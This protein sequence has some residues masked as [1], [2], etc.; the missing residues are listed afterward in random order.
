MINE[1]RNVPERRQRRGRASE[2][3]EYGQVLKGIKKE[4]KITYLMTKIDQFQNEG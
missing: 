1:Y 4:Q 2:M 3:E